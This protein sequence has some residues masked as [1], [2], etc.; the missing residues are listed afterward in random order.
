MRYSSTRYLCVKPVMATTLLLMGVDVDVSEVFG[1]GA[2]VRFVNTHFDWL[3]TIGS[4]EAR[5]AACEVIERA[6]FEDYNGPAIL[7]GDLNA[8]PKSAPL[9]RLKKLGWFFTDL[10]NLDV[11]LGAVQRLDVVG[12]EGATEG[13]GPWGGSGGRER[14]AAA[15]RG[16]PRC[17]RR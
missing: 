9:Q 1:E 2:S 13:D 15:S 5:L 12:Q 6:F 4:Q 11:A 14:T 8:T 7:A 17:R 16:R 10:G 3:K